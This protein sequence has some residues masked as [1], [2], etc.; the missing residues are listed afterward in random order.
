MSEANNFLVSQ[1]IDFKTFTDVVEAGAFLQAAFFTVSAVGVCVPW[2]G[3][4]A[5]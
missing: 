3:V 2:E 1:Q 4:Y 5:H